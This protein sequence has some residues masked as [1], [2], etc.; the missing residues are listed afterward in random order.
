M[1][2]TQSMLST[3][4][5]RNL[6][7]SYKELDT[8][9][10]QLNTGKKFSR[11]S[12][13]PV[14]AMK[15]INFRSELNQIEQYQRNTNEAT[16][17]FDNTD[18]ALDQINSGVQRIRYLAVQASN[19]T[20][21][22]AELES[23]RAEVNQIRNDLED[24]ANTKVNDQYIFNGTHTS[25]API[26]EGESYATFND[27]NVEIEVASGSMLPI[28]VSGEEVFGSGEDSLF[29][30]IDSF[31]EKL[32][33]QSDEPIDE[34]LVQLD[35]YIDQGIS[36]RADLGARMNRLELIENRLSQQEVVATSTLSE[37]EDVNF[38]EAI[39]KLMTQQ[40]IHQ[41]ALSSGARIMQPTLLDFL[42]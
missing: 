7:Q 34:T 29:G 14:S 6:N 24:M 30:V 12:E 5:L 16:N 23:I 22:D 18:A 19:G 26:P 40:S 36:A 11:P 32:S 25:T 41:A 38:A 27:A 13:D 35:D 17:W 42:R 2:V 20:Y 15:G 33:G 39:T 4:L 10:N 9:F 3:N 21:G 31:M 37:N 1:R 28:N 8:Y